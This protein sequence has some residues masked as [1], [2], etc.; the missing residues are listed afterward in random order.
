M[1]DSP[2][3]LWDTHTHILPSLDDGAA[4][5]ADAV[6][7]ATAAAQRGVTGIVATP[8]S[9]PVAEAGG[10]PL[11]VQRIEELRTALAERSIP[12]A[13]AP[14]MEVRLQR[15]TGEMLSQGAV[16]PLNGSRNVL[17]EFNYTEWAPYSTSALFDIEVAGFQPILA[18]VERIIPLQKHPDRVV[19]YVNRGYSAQI[20]A[21]SLLGSF[22][23]TAKHT[24]EQLL[25]E[26]VVHVVASDMH[27]TDG[28]RGPWP[29]E[30]CQVLE[31]QVGEEAAHLL[32]HV[33]TQRLVDGL[34]PLPI[35]PRPQQRHRFFMFR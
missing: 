23:T 30:T 3:S 16:V 21:V 9:L 35:V 11:L 2:R 27:A 32:V 17:I 7:M 34:P 5:L 13:I 4:S 10:P 6:E 25:A 18:H 1:V 15:D 22:G 8:H 31:R 26:G 14:G 24:A 20:T 29:S 19:D 28:H 33:N 12:V